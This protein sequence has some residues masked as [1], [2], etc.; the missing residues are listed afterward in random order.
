MNKHLKKELTKAHEEIQ[1]ANESLEQHVADRTVQ[2]EKAL[3]A[4]SEFL[5]NISHEIRSPM[6][7][8]VTTS[9]ILANDWDKL[10]TEERQTYAKEGFRNSQ[11]LLSLVSNLLDLSQM[12]VGKMTYAMQPNCNFIEV[13]QEIIDEC[14]A[15]LL[16]HQYKLE[17]KLQIEDSP[18]T[19]TFDTIRMMQVLRNLYT[20]AIK[21]TT[22]GV[23]T[24]T[25]AIKGSGKNAVIHF[26]LTDEGVGIP[27]EELTHIFEPFFQS[28]RT[29]T[30][31][32]GTGLGLNIAKQIIEAHH[33]RIWAENTP[34]KG[35]TFSFEIPVYHSLESIT[36]PAPPAIVPMAA[37]ILAIDD[38]KNCLMGL[39]LYLNSYG[40]EVFEAEGG[41]AGFDYLAQNYQHIDIVFLDLMMPDM[42]GLEVLQKIQK[43]PHLSNIPIILQ[44]GCSDQ[45]ELDKAWALGV[46]HIIKKPYNRGQLAEVVQLALE[47]KYVR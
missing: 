9:D 19:G 17:L 12:D 16:S 13:V 24:T 2:L 14:S 15:L 1:I 26:S 41:R 29:K 35:A 31:A 8:I 37:R 33:G 22:A 25:I 39:K 4:K 46:S 23:L 30:K 6:V 32:G 11:R 34:N 44:T 45:N 18:I 7:G 43:L 38:E 20:N 3:A 36:E 40:Y 42:D 28:S 21:F 10:T 5:R 47:Q 27:E